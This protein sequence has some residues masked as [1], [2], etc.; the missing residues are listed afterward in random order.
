MTPEQKWLLLYGSGWIDWVDVMRSD[1]LDVYE[2]Q[3][4]P[5]LFEFDPLQN[6]IRLKKYESIRVHVAS[7]PGIHTVRTSEDNSRVPYNKP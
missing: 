3:F 7:S 2:N 6:R 5:D 1:A 4:D